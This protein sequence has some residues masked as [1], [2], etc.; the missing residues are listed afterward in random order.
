MLAIN[1]H[2]PAA[3]RAESIP[4]INISSLPVYRLGSTIPFLIVDVTSPPARYAP[5]NSNM[6]AIKTACFKVIALLPTDVP[7]ALA[8]SL[9][10]I[11]NAMKK[12]ANA[13][14][15]RIKVGSRNSVSIIIY[16][17]YFI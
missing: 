5:R 15:I 6:A 2:V 8:T 4:I 17:I 11:P 9:A 12:P 14:I 7:I 13:A 3:R 16:V 1:N 10:P